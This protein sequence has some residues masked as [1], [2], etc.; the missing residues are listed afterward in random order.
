VKASDH[1]VTAT[2]ELR[3]RY[4]T[5]EPS[6]RIEPSPL[7]IYLHG[8]GETGDD[9]DRLERA[10]LPRMLREGLELP[11]VVVCPQCRERWDPLELEILL[12]T[13]I[14]SGRFDPQRIYLCGV[15]L[16]AM[17]TWAFANRVA[18]RLA[19]IVPIC[20]PA[21]RI[22]AEVFR[23]LPVRCIHGALDTVVPI[24]ESVTMVRALR[25]AGCPIT[26]DVYPDTD[27]NVWDLCL[28]PDLWRWLLAQRRPA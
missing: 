6:T 3:V 28:G 14:E 2:Q 8:S 19:A 18:S 1:A 24:G 22:D 21:V 27:H 9:L 10:G 13:L 15:S 20:G 7:L 17:G 4:R 16:G 26:F 12:N 25:K 23:S 11:F 5:Y